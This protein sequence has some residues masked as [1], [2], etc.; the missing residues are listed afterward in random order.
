MKSAIH[1]TYTLTTKSL[2]ME[3][4]KKK[5]FGISMREGARELLCYPDISTNQTYVEKFVQLCQRNE[6]AP[7]HLVDV[8][9]DYLP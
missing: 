6:V 4:E 7:C 9:Y 5:V 2:L 1:Y 8:L 3:G